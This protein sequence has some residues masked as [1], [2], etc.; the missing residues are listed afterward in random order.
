MISLLGGWEQGQSK[1]YEQTETGGKG[2]GGETL[3]INSFHYRVAAT[4]YSWFIDLVFIMLSLSLVCVLFSL[5]FLSLITLIVLY[6]SFNPHFQILIYFTS[7][8]H[9]CIK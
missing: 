9:R 2:T 3:L 5:P 6:S 7:L 1:K 4:E 8:Y